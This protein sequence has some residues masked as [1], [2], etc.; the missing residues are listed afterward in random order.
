MIGLVPIGRLAARTLGGG[1]HPRD[2]YIGT[3]DALTFPLRHYSVALA[4]RIIIGL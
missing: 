1:I 3:P 2:P 4:T